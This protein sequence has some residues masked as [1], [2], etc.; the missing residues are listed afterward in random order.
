MAEVH[1][2][3]NL[4]I[5]RAKSCGRQYMRDFRCRNSTK[6]HDH[7]TGRKCESCGGMLYDTIINFGENLPKKALEDGFD[8]SQRSDLCLV[9]GSSLRIPPAADMPIETLKQNG[10][11]V[12]VK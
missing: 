11:L 6:V 7:K 5:C 9:L 8:Q 1:G 2:N 3:S 4:E 12:I 10:R